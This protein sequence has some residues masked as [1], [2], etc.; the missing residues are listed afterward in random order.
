MVAVR[1][2][3]ATLLERAS[4]RPRSTQPHATKLVPP[5]ARHRGTERTPR[6]CNLGKPQRSNPKCGR[7]PPLTGRAQLLGRWSDPKATLRGHAAPEL[8]SIRYRPRTASFAAR[9]SFANRMRS[10]AL[11]SAG[12]L[13]NVSSVEN[14]SGRQDEEVA[15]LVTTGTSH[16]AVVTRLCDVAGDAVDAGRSAA[17][18]LHVIGPTRT[19]HIPRRSDPRLRQR[20]VSGLAAY[21]VAA[22]GVLGDKRT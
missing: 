15:W 5:P 9:R 2:K 4:T 1:A 12:R 7:K 13:G 20:G 8:P 21:L 14:A 22:V 18:G 10:S 3:F 11:P 16:A 19:A 6:A 17:V